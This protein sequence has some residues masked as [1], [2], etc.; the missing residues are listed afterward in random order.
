VIAAKKTLVLVFSFSSPF[1]LFASPFQYLIV[2]A[3]Q[4]GW[5]M[6]AC[7]GIAKGLGDDWFWHVR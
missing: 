1:G 6:V 4:K 3:Y 2:E 5:Y 7:F